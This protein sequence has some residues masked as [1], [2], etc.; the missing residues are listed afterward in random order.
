MTFSLL[1][2]PFLFPMNAEFV[3][4][5][6]PF[7]E[8]LKSS[9]C[10]SRFFPQRFNHLSPLFSQRFAVFRTN[11]GAPIVF[12][13]RTFWLLPSLP[14]PLYQT[15]SSGSHCEVLAQF[16]T[17]LNYSRPHRFLFYH[18]KTAPRQIPSLVPSLLSPFHFFS[19]PVS[20][21]HSFAS[22]VSPPS[23]PSR[24]LFLLFP[25]PLLGFHFP[26]L[27]TLPFS[28][29][30]PPPFPPRPSGLTSPPSPLL[31]PL[32]SP[33]FSPL[34]AFSL[35]WAEKGNAGELL[36]PDFSH[37]GADLQRSP[38]PPHNHLHAELLSF[39]S[40]RRRFSGP[41]R[42]NRP[43]QTNPLPTQILETPLRRCVYYLPF[44]CPFRFHFF[45]AGALLFVCNRSLR[46]PVPNAIPPQHPRGPGPKS[47]RPKRLY[48]HVRIFFFLPTSPL[49]F[50][51]DP[52]LS[53][54]PVF[55]RPIGPHLDVD[56]IFRTDLFL[57]S[58]RSSTTVVIHPPFRPGTNSPTGVTK[59]RAHFCP[60]PRPDPTCRRNT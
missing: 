41:T 17:R 20:N 5:F 22:P 27:R 37:W 44:E 8:E 42:P 48:F 10:Q 11:L 50:P 15:S 4:V 46:T 31:W 49:L 56:P 9:P 33:Y 43:A 36:F 51:P 16:W 3:V 30:F 52:I 45:F 60:G 47:A 28:L 34:L 29:F 54:F 53:D 13:P 21:P 40:L 7:P 35:W 2:N 18:A 23:L 1:K 59:S 14:A 12:N 32:L 39:S 25:P 6:F 57:A 26:V 38:L 19:Q 24:P 58:C 55:P